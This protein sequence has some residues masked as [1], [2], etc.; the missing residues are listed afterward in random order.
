MER[1]PFIYVALALGVGF[2]ALC[3]WI[4]AYF[5]YRN[6]PSELSTK[7]KVLGFM[8]GGPF[9]SALHASLSARGY[10]LTLF[11]KVGLVV[12][13]AVVVVLAIG[14]VIHGYVRT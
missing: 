1:M 13:V 2:L 9:F 5:Y 11:E 12:V 14:G 6:R 10:K 4:A 3:A 8:L 7:D